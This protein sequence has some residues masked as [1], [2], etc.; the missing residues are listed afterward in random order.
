MIRANVRI[1][2]MTLGDLAAQVAATTV[3]E[4]A[5]QELA[6]RYGTGAARGA[7]DRPDRA[8]RAARPAGD[9]RLARRH[10]RRSPT[11]S[12]RTGSSGATCRSSAT[13]TIDGDELTA[14]L[15]ESSPMV[16][17]ALNS[18]RSFI[19]ACVYQAVRSALA[20]EIPNTSGAF[21]PIHVLTKPGTICEVV[22]PGASSMRGVTGF[23]AL[24]AI[25]GALAQLIPSRVPAAGEGGNTLAVFG[26]DRPGR[27]RAVHLL[28]ADRRH[29][30]RHAARPTATTASRTR[31]ASRRTSRSRSPSRSS[32]S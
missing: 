15:R 5:L 32:R 14:D 22:M 28:R 24:D 6:R 30:G 19:Q 23:R 10:A 20:V 21:R 18:T 25:N 4:R 16:A 26:A 7:D 31:R 11:T 27:R 1:P 13:V 9:R 3:A 8:H 29:V 2:R 17:G 12:T